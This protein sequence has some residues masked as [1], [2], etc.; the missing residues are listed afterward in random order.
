MGN[1]GHGGFLCITQSHLILK[2]LPRRGAMVR[3]FEHMT[4]QGSEKLNILPKV[5][6]LACG[7]AA[8]RLDSSQPRSRACVLDSHVFLSPQA[9]EKSPKDQPVSLHGMTWWP[10][11]DTGGSSGL[12]PGST[13]PCQVEEG[14]LSLPNSPSTLPRRHDARS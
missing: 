3:R 1:D 13:A 14:Q 8:L 5:T 9:S 6:Q 10:L 12:Q 2:T 7:G 4:F 11:K